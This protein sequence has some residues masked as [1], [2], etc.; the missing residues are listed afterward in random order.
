MNGAAEVQPGTTSTH[1]LLQGGADSA[2]NEFFIRS[3]MKVA[4]LGE[5]TD[6]STFDELR[7]NN[8]LPIKTGLE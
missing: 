4:K 6:P 8:K 3:Q 5:S 2:K 7:P 1:E